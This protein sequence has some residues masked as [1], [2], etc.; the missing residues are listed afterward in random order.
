MK[1]I[2]SG[3]RGCRLNSL[4]NSKSQEDNMAEVLPSTWLNDLNINRYGVFEQANMTLTGSPAFIVITGETGVGKSVLMSALEYALCSSTTKSNNNKR[5]FIFKDSNMGNDDMK[6]NG[7]VLLED[8][9]VSLSIG[10]NMMIKRGQ[11][12]NSKRSMC[13]LNGNR[14]TIKALGEKVAGM[15]KFWSA[16]KS[17]I[18]SDKAGLAKNNKARNE[19]CFLTHV[20]HNLDSRGKAT[21]DELT[22]VYTDWRREY[23]HLKKLQG[24]QE[25]M[26][27]G[28]DGELLSFW[29][30]ELRETQKESEKVFE[31]LRKILEELEEAT[32][33]STTDMN[34]GGRPAISWNMLKEQQQQRQELN[35]NDEGKND[36]E[37]EEEKNGENYSDNRVEDPDE[38]EYE[39]E[40]VG[41][42][43]TKVDRSSSFNNN[44]NDKAQRSPIRELMDTLDVIG[45]N[46]EN[47]QIRN[48][49]DV[50]T[51]SEQLLATLHDAIVRSLDVG[52]P[53]EYSGDKE[54]ME[55]L[56]KSISIYSDKLITLQEAFRE[57]G[58]GDN[59]LDGRMEEAHIAL[60]ESIGSIRRA[61]VVLNKLQCT[62]PDLSPVQDRLSSLKNSYLEKARKH[63][64]GNKVI[65]LDRLKTQWSSDLDTVSTYAIDY[66]IVKRKERRLR[67][68][69]ASLAWTLSQCRA[70]SATELVQKVNLILPSLEMGDKELEVQIATILSSLD[71]PS[72][73]QQR[74]Y[75]EN[76]K[77]NDNDID[78]YYL[79]LAALNPLRAGIGPNGWDEVQLRANS[80]YIKSKTKNSDGNNNNNN[81]FVDVPGL[82]PPV[83]VRQ[84][85]SSGEHARLSLAIETCSFRDRSYDNDYDS[86]NQSDTRREK[87]IVYD[88]IDAHVGGEAA[89]A[90]ARLL[91]K[92]GACRQVIA[93]THNPIIAAAADQHFVVKRRSE[94][95]MNRSTNNNVDDDTEMAGLSVVE[96]VLGETREAELARMATGKLDTNAGT[97]LAKALLDEFGTSQKLS[98]RR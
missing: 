78:P 57:V 26:N 14:V 19:N 16:D 22:N 29:L 84:T 32:Y 53:D 73:E 3:S 62:L 96:Q 70:K 2:S 76:E 27:E 30:T 24:V 4:S 28:R 10:A 25:R 90:V 56:E 61:N 45:K 42:V 46:P 77:D 35:D 38:D 36:D 20:D 5:N 52:V 55:T 94:H 86:N 87:M 49:W 59:G 43:K 33:T 98:E 13:E 82:L 50:I 89:V 18:I 85:L 66:P 63:K 54:T 75:N 71:M 39:D 37:K 91:K 17:D 79:Y 15:V 88:E 34:T 21:L 60:Q 83:S 8:T 67:C 51:M 81:L 11:V 68:K 92:Q 69:Y 72:Q 31:D 41:M 40:I 74:Q 64:L 6:E 1:P 80:L 97:D 44:T 65:E 9:F 12:S 7:H 58:L 95:V 48:N 23:L 47:G 93:I